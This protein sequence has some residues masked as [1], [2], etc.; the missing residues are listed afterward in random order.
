VLPLV[1]EA[2]GYTSPYDTASVQLLGACRAI[3]AVRTG[4]VDRA[5]EL[6]A[7]TLRAVDQTQETWAQADLRRWLSEL[8]R[9]T[10]NV[11]LERRMLLEASELYGRKEI[12]SYDDDIQT[13]LDEL[14]RQATASAIAETEFIEH[15]TGAQ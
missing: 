14:A 3:L 13:R 9:T 10:G 7:E 12:R 4:D 8:P 5:T 11:A 15:V 2:E 6:A 1:E